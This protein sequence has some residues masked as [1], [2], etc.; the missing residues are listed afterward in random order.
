MTISPGWYQDPAEPNTQR[1]WDGAGWIGAPLPKDVAPPPGPP[2]QLIPGQAGPARPGQRPPTRVPAGPPIRPHGLALATPGARMLARLI[3]IGVVLLL[4][5][6]INGWFVYKW[7]QTLIPLMQTVLTTGDPLPE[8]RTGD[9]DKLSIIITL[10][11]LALWFAY[12]VP[13]TAQSGQTLGKR[14][15][16]IKVVRAESLE[17]IGMLRSWRRWNPMA[18]PLLFLFFCGPFVFIAQILD[19]MF[20]AIDS[21]QRMAWHDRSAGTFVVQLPGSPGKKGQ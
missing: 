6:A 12:E 21:T 9:L 16:R 2:P 18:L 4:N 19:V 15:M 13:S 10:L 3:D 20:V 11:G 14:L 7:F 5:G 17:P 8:A 1:Y